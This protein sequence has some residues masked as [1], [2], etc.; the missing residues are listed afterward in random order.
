MY[1]AWMIELVLDV[2][3]NN[4]NDYIESGNPDSLNRAA[5]WL[6]SL[7]Y[8]RDERGGDN[9]KTIQVS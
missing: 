4:V 1:R 8:L 3:M 2:L 9:E 5:S 6:E 7:P